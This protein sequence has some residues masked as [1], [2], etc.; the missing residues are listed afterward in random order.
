M[1]SAKEES[2]PLKS[3]KKS[4]VAPAYQD[5]ALPSDPTPI[6]SLSTTIR[7][8]GNL[9]FKYSESEGLNRNS[10]MSYLLKAVA[11]YENAMKS[12]TDNCDRSKASKNLAVS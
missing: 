8:K 5:A 9:E 11:H 2:E 7:M 1:D 12:A 6:Q 10:R 3:V 4:G